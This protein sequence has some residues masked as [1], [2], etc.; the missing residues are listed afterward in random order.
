VLSAL[1]SSELELSTATGFVPLMARMPGRQE[2]AEHGWTLDVSDC[3]VALREWM[4]E[5]QGL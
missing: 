3:D 2:A 1:S 5:R 4:A